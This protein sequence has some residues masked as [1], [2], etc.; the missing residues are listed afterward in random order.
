MKHLGTRLGGLELTKV[1]GSGGFGTVYRGEPDVGP[2]R[3]VKVLHDPGLATALRDE[4]ATLAALNHPRIVGFIHADL[5][6]EP[7]YIATELVEGGP[8][9]DKLPMSEPE[10]LAVCRG[11]LE[12]LALPHSQ[13][14]AH[15]DLKPANVLMASDGP[16]ITDFGLARAIER[17][18]VSLQQSLTSFKGATTG[19]L[20]FMAPEQREGHRGDQRSDIYSLGVM[21]AQILTG[22]LPQPGDT[23]DELLEQP[24]PRWATVLF[25]GSYCRVDKRFANASEA[26]HA[27]DE[28]LEGNAP[29]AV[30]SPGPSKRS[31]SPGARLGEGNTQH[32]RSC[33]LEIMRKA[34]ACPGCG[35]KPKAAG[36]FCKVCGGS[37]KPKTSVCHSC[38]T[39]QWEL[40]TLP[41]RQSPA[42]PMLLCLLLA[43]FAPCGIHR[44]AMGHTNS[45]ILQLLLAWFCV[46]GVF[47]SW[48]DAVLIATGSLRMEDGR[49]L[50]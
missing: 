37:M 44:L 30:A 45:G 42:Q 26:L 15:L 27:L 8:L 7:P 5:H 39:R 50:S 48:F 32:C 46:I 35:C 10:A 1:I 24:A 13:G 6:S 36:L 31:A 9:S 4:A 47:W 19:T 21:L 3:A 12:G 22:K 16:K 14:I 33:G 49:P 23:L 11:I 17:T 20:A 29:A 28:A 2:A 43:I 38:G 25:E 18:G 40:R 34:V 41:L